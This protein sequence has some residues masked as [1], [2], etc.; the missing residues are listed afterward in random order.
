MALK[1]LLQSWDLRVNMRGQ[2]WNSKI[3]GRL[4]VQSRRQIM[5]AHAGIVGVG[6]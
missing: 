6:M 4:V 1:A 5:E 3:A 2:K